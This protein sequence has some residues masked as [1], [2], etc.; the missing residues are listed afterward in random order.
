MPSVVSVLVL[1]THLSPEVS[2]LWRRCCQ[3]REHLR[4]LADA[5]RDIAD[6]VEEVNI[7]A[8]EP[9]VEA[10]KLAMGDGT[11]PELN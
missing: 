10:L 11:T 5:K 7:Q 6:L 9:R 1:F 8:R 3:P 2:G 4:Q